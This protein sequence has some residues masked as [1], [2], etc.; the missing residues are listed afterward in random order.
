M[1]QIRKALVMACSLAAVS[2]VAHADDHAVARRISS[3]GK[4]SSSHAK[5]LA[6]KV[7]ERM[8]RAADAP[9]A[10]IEP[11]RAALSQALLGTPMPPDGISAAKV[12]LKLYAGLNEF[13]LEAIFAPRPGAIAS[14]QRDLELTSK[15]CQALVAAAGEVSVAQA[16]R[17]GGGPAPAPVA[18]GPMRG[19]P[20]GGGRFGGGYPQQAPVQQGYARQAPPQQQGGSRFGGGA[21]QQQSRFGGAAPQQQSRFGGQ[22]AQQPMA[23][24]PQRPVQQQPTAAPQ[25]ASRFAGSAPAQQQRFGNAAPVQAAPAAA[26]AYVAAA[27][28]PAATVTAEDAAKRK[29][30]YAAKRAEYMAR[31]KQEFEERRAKLMGGSA[32]AASD[33]PSEAPAPAASKPAE[34]A[35]P[36]AVAAAPSKKAAP[37]PSSDPMDGPMREPE[38]A[39]ELDDEM[40]GALGKGAAA[41]APGAGKA[42]FDGDFLDGLLDDPTGG[43]KK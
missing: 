22:A 41:P 27:P 8:A 20:Q 10:M 2:G 12:R 11:L 34:A 21:P 13:A 32:A 19:A 18:M 26:P 25:Q 29:E 42:G 33:G 4:I 35:T 38:P 37:E 1:T 5:Q 6:S 3:H 16:K 36:A 31:K 43:K 9:P 14:C 15:E 24:A 39:N 30:E 23:A 40:K 17:S 7:S 28:A